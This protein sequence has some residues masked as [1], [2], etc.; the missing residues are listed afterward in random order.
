MNQDKVRKGT[1]REEKQK[2]HPPS[3]AVCHLSC[4]FHS[5]EA[6]SIT[7]YYRTQETSHGLCAAASTA[8][9]GRPR[10]R[11][12]AGGASSP[13]GPRGAPAAGQGA[14]FHGL[15]GR[16]AVADPR[17]PGAGVRGVRNQRA[18]TTG[19]RRHGDPLQAPLRRHRCRRHHRQRRSALR[20]T[21]G[22]HGCALH[23]GLLPLLSASS[24]SMVLLPFP[25]SC[26]AI[27]FIF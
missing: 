12:L 27:L 19:A 13:G 15:D 17:E 5:R 25:C 26:D 23:A 11:C 21:P 16:S 3:S 10:R 20:R 6:L 14:G 2:R 9:P 22:G 4:S 18:C 7:E 8:R 24:S 1:E